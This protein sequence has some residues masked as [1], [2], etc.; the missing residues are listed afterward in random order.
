MS[1]P[2][3]QLQTWLFECCVQ[4]ALYFFGLM[5]WDEPAYSALE[6]FLFGALEI[7]LLYALLRP[8]EAW[9]PVEVWTD[10]TATRVD[11]VY[12]MLHRLGLIPLAMFALLTPV[13]TPLEASLRLHGLIPANLED[14]LPGVAPMSALGFVAYVVVLDFAEYVRHRLQHRFG[15]WWALHSLHHSQRQMSFWNDDRNHLLDDV[16]A[17]LWF[18]AIAL[19]IGVPP[20][21]FVLIAALMRAVESLSH[22]NLRWHFGPIGARLLVGP[23][24]HR[25]HHG[26]GVGHE[27][28]ARGCNF[29]TLFP[30]WDI[31]FGTADFSRDYPATGIRD[32]L[33]GAH[34]GDGFWQQQ[35]LGL[36]RLRAALAGGDRAGVGDSTRGA[37]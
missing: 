25:R 27:G 8:L 22:A 20:G 10:R 37:S 36:K 21:Q 16:L 26:I 31:A 4:P 29:A 11:V 18:A 3:A 7:A 30:L 2:L 19:L 35:W 13:W 14:W 23:H 24:Y 32:Q 1:D 15:W 28:R 34:Y 5:Y 6:I 12:T 9:R 17:D 33:Q